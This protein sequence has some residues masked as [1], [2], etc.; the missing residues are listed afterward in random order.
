MI[1]QALDGLDGNYWLRPIT[2]RAA[3]EPRPV[4]HTSALACPA[5]LGVPRCAPRQKRGIV[6]ALDLG[7]LVC[8]SY[9]MC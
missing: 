4:S 9:P 7:A 8:L 3:A 1:R 5:R 2:F 6:L